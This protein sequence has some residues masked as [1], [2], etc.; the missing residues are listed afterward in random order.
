MSK[1][2]TIWERRTGEGLLA[3]CDD[4][5]ADILVFVVLGESI[6]DFL[7]EGAGE[8]VEGFRAVEGDLS[9]NI[10]SIQFVFLLLH[11]P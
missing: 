5:R 8:G 6:V 4:N 2:G 1:G 10:V 3:A 11:V 9:V 7:E